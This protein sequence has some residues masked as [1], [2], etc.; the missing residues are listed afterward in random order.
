MLTIDLTDETET[1]LTSAQIDLLDLIEHEP[2]AL[3]LDA[4]WEQLFEI[5]EELTRRARPVAA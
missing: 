4:C 1:T 5:T 2:D 3:K